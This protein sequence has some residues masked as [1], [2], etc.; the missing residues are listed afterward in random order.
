MHDCVFRFTRVFRFTLVF[1][2][3]RVFAFTHGEVT[4]HQRP[5]SALRRR[6]GRIAPNWSVPWKSGSRHVRRTGGRAPKPHRVPRVSRTGI[7]RASMPRTS[8]DTRSNSPAGDTGL[9]VQ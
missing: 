9:T 8:P 7:F 5:C 6:R 3:T 1:G 4:H 2:F